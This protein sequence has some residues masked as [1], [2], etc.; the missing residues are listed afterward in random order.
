[1]HEG[2]ICN[3]IPFY[4][5]YYALHIVHFVLERG[6]CDFSKLKRES[7]YKM[8]IVTSGS[9]NLHINGK[10]MPITRGSLFFTFPDFLFAIEPVTEDF[11]YMYISFLGARGNMLLD[12]Q[13]INKQNFLFHNVPKVEVFWKEAI[14]YKG[15]IMA[16]KGETAL[17]YA[18]SVLGESLYEEKENAQETKICFVIKKYIDDNYPNPEFSLELIAR[19]LRYNRKY[20]STVFKRDMGLGVVEYLQK[21]RIQH[22]CTMIEQGSESVSDIAFQSGFSD[23]QYFSK[24]FKKMI[25]SSPKEYIQ[26]LKKA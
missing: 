25:G 4:K 21:V 1:M 2:N 8:H 18:F 3:F 16:L 10:I 20:I 5:D 19:E 6:K 14:M 13:K 24:V 17:L 22:A 23:P 26:N 15:S 7:L 11:E 9:G 12:S